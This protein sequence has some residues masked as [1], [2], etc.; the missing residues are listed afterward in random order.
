[1]IHARD[2]IEPSDIN[3]RRS[4]FL[5]DAF[6]KGEMETFAILL[7]LFFQARGEWGSFAMLDLA[8]WLEGAHKTERFVRELVDN[9]FGSLPR[10]QQLLREKGH[11]YAAEGRWHV[12]DEFILRCYV[13]ASGVDRPLRRFFVFLAELPCPQLETA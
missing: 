11:L 9:P 7:V 5:P 1:M 6:G 8:T 2:Y 3:V 12:T 10:G 4:H 13:V